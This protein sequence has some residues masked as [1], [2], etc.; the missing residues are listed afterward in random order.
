MSKITLTNL[1]DLSNENSAVTTI[2]NNMQIIQTEMDNTL[3][4]DGTSPNQMSATM[5]MNSKRI[6]NLPAP[7]SSTEPVRVADLAG[8]SAVTVNNLPTGGT[9]GQVLSKID[10]T[11]YNVQWVTSGTA[12][13]ATPLMDGVAATGVASPYSREDHVHPTDTSRAPTA[14]PTFTGTITAATTNTTVLSASTSL[15]TPIV[16]SGTSL[17]FQTNGTTQAGLITSGQQ[18][19]IGNNLTP[20]SGTGLTINGNTV[21]PPAISGLGLNPFVTIVGPD[22][23][24]PVLFMQGFGSSA[25]PSL[26]FGHSRG[27]AASPT[28]TQ[29][30]DFVAEVFAHPF[31]ADGT[32]GYV[33]SAGSGLIFAATENTTATTAGQELRVYTT[34][35]GSVTAGLAATFGNGGTLTCTAGIL[36]T[37]AIFGVGYT[38]GAGG[39]VT[40]ITSRTT[41]VTINKVSGAITLVSAAGTATHQVMTINNN[42]IAATDTISINQKSG[43]DKYIIHVIQVANASFSI[44]YATTGGTTTEQPVFQYNV[45]RGS[46][47]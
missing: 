17:T 6:I 34:P 38:T 14:S 47:S 29:S 35:T 10:G 46:N 18:W 42:T 5:D 11:S 20:Q 7:I 40:Q 26:V 27:T 36:S 16:K 41:P 4:R 31:H 25:E 22:A 19:V 32:P 30:G 1:A 23:T 37:S 45:I 8:G 43:T 39:T 3:S 12:S 2:N 28:A 21:T 15:T 9:T 24:R 13:S 33:T 44:T